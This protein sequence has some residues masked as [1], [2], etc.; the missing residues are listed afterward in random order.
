MDTL[1]YRRNIQ[2][3]SR[4]PHNTA[5]LETASSSWLIFETLESKAAG[6]PTLKARFKGETITMHSAYNPLREAEKMIGDRDF[7]GAETLLIFGF[8]LGYHCEAALRML[9][10]TRLIIVDLVP[11]LFKLAL[12]LRDFSELFSSPRVT[13]IAGDYPLVREVIAR[14][15]RQAGEESSGAARVFVFPPELRIMPDEAT[16]FRDILEHLR[17]S[18]RVTPVFLNERKANI[19]ANAEAL[20]RSR[21]VAELFDSRTGGA[22][23]VAASGPSLDESLPKLAADGAP[24]TIICVDSALP[25]LKAAGLQAD[26]VVTADP[27]AH[28][29]TLF[30]HA[31]VDEE[32]LIFFPSSNPEIVRRFAP[33][34][35]FA[36]FSSTSGLEKDMPRAEAKGRLFLSGTVFLAA[37]D[38]AVKMAPPVIVM[39]GADF[40]V[41]PGRTHAAG[42]RAG[43]LTRPRMGRERPVRGIHGPP[44]TTTEVLYLYLRDTEN[45]LASTPRKSLIVNAGAQGAYV[46]GAEHLPLEKILARIRNA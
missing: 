13:V 1:L 24:G 26:F 20:E 12:S 3:L 14:V 27:Q 37:L 10:D 2:L 19:E 43:D 28:T 40:A 31:H 42:V 23:F 30:D 15:T 9:P 21:G 6:E 39:V 25:P 44:V 32:N 41:R 17:L 36:A 22:V 8:G 29:A 18:Q 38:L 34:R 16:E 33:D 46:T 4:P 11:A 7:A 5:G 35:R 45:Y